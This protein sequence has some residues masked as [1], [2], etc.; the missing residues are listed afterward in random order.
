MLGSKCETFQNPCDSSPC[1][2]EGTCN[3]LS[4]TNNTI[5]YSC[6]CK[7]GY[8]GRNC[9]VKQLLFVKMNTVQVHSRKKLIESKICSYIL[10]NVP[11][12]LVKTMV[13]V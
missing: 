12:I 13:H 11:L 3:I 10:T 9:E 7:N 6:T 4:F 1:L 8:S 5:M 2:N